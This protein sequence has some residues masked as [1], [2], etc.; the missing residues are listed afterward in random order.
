MCSLL[1]IAIFGAFCRVLTAEFTDYDGNL[2]VTQNFFVQRGL[3]AESLKWAFT[4]VY[5]A[6]WQPLTWLSFMLDHELY[7]LKPAGYHLTNLLLHIANTL[8]LFGVL[9]QMTGSAERSAFVAGLFALHPLR[10]E[11]VAWVAERKDVLSSF[12]WMLTMWAY[13]RYVQ[14]PRIKTYIP[15]IIFFVLGLMSKPMLVTVP[16]VLLLLDY[17]PLG[18]TLFSRCSSNL[19]CTRLS[20]K[21]LIFE[22]VPLFILS[23]LSSIIA[24]IAQERGGALSSLDKMSLGIRLANAAVSYIA[25]IRQMIWPTNL[26]VLYPHPRDTIPILQVIG[27]IFLLI[28]LSIIVLRLTGRGPYMGV[29][30]A[31]YLGTLVPVIGFVQIGAHA[32]ADRFTYIPMIGL[33][34]VIAWRLPE[35]AG[36]I[37]IDGKKGELEKEQV[38]CFRFFRFSILPITAIIVF[39]AFG[40]CSWVQTGYWQNS[41]ALFKRAVGV[42]HGNSIAM[43]NL[44]GVLI[45]EGRINE[46]KAYLMRAVELRPGARAYNNLGLVAEKEGKIDKAIDYFLEAIKY[47][48]SYIGAYYNLAN[49]LIRER[50]IEEAVS[51]HKKQLRSNQRIPTCMSVSP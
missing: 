51:Y 43:V 19:V 10:V 11:S 16:F 1:V 3:N 17:W 29:G 38:S 36:C 9:K 2:Y 49:L 32:M 12:F 33:F 47:D 40:I 21:R 31:W 6:T 15:V 4:A 25:Y 35:L 46:A 23:I 41:I 8:L 7:G 37:R 13:V 28:F 45:R 5:A 27:A 26:G 44:A 50:R 24:Y 42:T 39:I 20:N 18:R 30:W 34:V 48:P 22:K 14:F